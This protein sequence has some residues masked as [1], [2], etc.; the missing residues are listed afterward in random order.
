MKEDRSI[1]VAEAPSV[2]LLLAIGGQ[3]LKADSNGTRY[4]LHE[5]ALVPK[6]EPLLPEVLESSIS[7]TENSERQGFIE[8]VL[9]NAHDGKPPASGAAPH[10]PSGSNS[11]QS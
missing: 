10:S 3:L 7:A 2:D 1:L 11:H 4:Y 8:S 6:G 5:V 9:R